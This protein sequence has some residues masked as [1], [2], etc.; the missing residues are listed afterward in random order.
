MFQK[1]EK[2]LEKEK[3]LLPRIN[4]TCGETSNLST[5]S[6]LQVD[7]IFTQ[8]HLLKLEKYTDRCKK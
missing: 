7:V 2:R 5:V 4:I 6:A 3:Y 1:I 8:K